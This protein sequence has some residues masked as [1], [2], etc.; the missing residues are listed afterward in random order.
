V[1]SKNRRVYS[2]E[3][4]KAFI[5]KSILLFMANI[6]EAPTLSNAV[7]PEVA[8]IIVEKKN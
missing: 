3:K 2:I 8:V 4:S 6:F 5:P 7:K 1:S